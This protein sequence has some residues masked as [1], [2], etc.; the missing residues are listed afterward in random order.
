[1][2]KKLCSSKGMTL[3]ELLVALMIVAL[4]GVSLTVGV[5]GAVKV[6]R[7]ATRLYEAE[8][9]C[10]TI[11]TYLEDEFRFSRNIRNQTAGGER[12]VIFD[13]QVFGK[14]VAVFVND[15]GKIEI[16]EI[17]KSSSRSKLLSDKAYTS[18]LKVSEDD[19]KITYDEASG[20]VTIKI[21]VSSD[22]TGAYV[23]HTV[24]VA[25]VDD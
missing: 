15:N 8:T 24:E 3:T 10:G 22:N 18:G 6:Y 19:C 23:E 5:N 17:G 21:A 9:L 25:P 13:S 14:D 1:M 2:R 11:L 4:I 16:G 20:Q 12:T 7:D